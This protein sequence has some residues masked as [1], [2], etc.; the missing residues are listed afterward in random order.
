MRIIA[1]W[2]KSKV[3]Q[4][5]LIHSSAL[6]DQQALRDIQMVSSFPVLSH[7]WELRESMRNEESQT[8]REESMCYDG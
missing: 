6:P 2:R 7:H 3:S 4:L 5:Y 1:K 8:G